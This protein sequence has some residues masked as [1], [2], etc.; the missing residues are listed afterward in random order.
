ML[1]LIYHFD[2]IVNLLAFWSGT[3]KFRAIKV[4]LDY[5]H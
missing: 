5:V 4:D 2:N 3:I 1:G